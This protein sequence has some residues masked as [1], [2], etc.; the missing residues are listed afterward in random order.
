LTSLGLSLRWEVELDYCEK[1]LIGR[2]G[3]IF[4]RAQQAPRHLDRSQ[5]S[6]P[7]RSDASALINMMAVNDLEQLVKAGTHLLLTQSSPPRE[8]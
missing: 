5:L 8:D 4:E 3:E 6:T 7:A 2:W 1:K